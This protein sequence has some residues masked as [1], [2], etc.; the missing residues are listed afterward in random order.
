M[1]CA[2]I[3]YYEQLTHYADPHEEA[4]PVTGDGLVNQAS[5]AFKY[6]GKRRVINHLYGG[7]RSGGRM[8]VGVR[9]EKSG[10]VGDGAL[11]SKSENQ[12]CG[13]GCGS[14]SGGRRSRGI[15]GAGSSLWSILE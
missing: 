2:N 14:Q 15:E 3:L 9:L 13:G 5:P 11:T 4:R 12:P 7:E 1:V 8:C 10:R 6:R